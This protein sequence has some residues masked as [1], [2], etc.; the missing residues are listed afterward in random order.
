MMK[1]LFFII[2]LSFFSFELFAESNVDK[3][4]MRADSLIKSFEES[5]SIVDANKAVR[6]FV[7]DSYKFN[8]DEIID[9]VKLQVYDCYSQYLFNHG[10]FTECYKNANATLK[11]AISSD[12]F[13]IQSS[14]YS[15][16]SLCYEHWGDYEK[17]IT[18]AKKSFD[19]E[20]ING[21]PLE[22]AVTLNNISELYYTIGRY[23]EALE[24]NKKF[25]DMVSKIDDQEKK[26]R[27]TSIAYGSASMIYNGL[28]Q[29]ELAYELAEKGYIIDSLANRHEAASIR[30]YQMAENLKDMGHTRD[31][32]AFFE[33]L[34]D[35]TNPYSFRR[36]RKIDFLVNT[37][38]NLKQHEEALKYARE[39]GDIHAQQINLRY[40]ALEEEDHE[41]AVADMEESFQLLD[42]M[43]VIK[44][45]ALKEGLYAD[46]QHSVDEY[47]NQMHS[48]KVTM[49]ASVLILL[50]AFLAI[51][52]FGWIRNRKICKKL[53]K[54]D[55]VKDNLIKII[56]RELSNSVFDINTYSHLLSDNVNEED[57]K[58]LISCSDSQKQVLENILVWSRMHCLDNEELRKTDIQMRSFVQDAIV[59]NR[60]LAENKNVIL[61]CQYSEDCTISS[62]TAFLNIL[63]DSLISN[64]V[65]ASEEGA[66]VIIRFD[67]NS[68]SVIDSGKLIDEKAKSILDSKV[69]L[70]NNDKV[71]LSYQII[72]DVLKILGLSFDIVSKEEEGNNFTVKF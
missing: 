61:V 39:T 7:G 23:K 71:F 2:L 54:T 62:D 29:Y 70:N 58:S 57:L 11:K 8:N 64:A 4:L 19:I 9:D 3:Q 41:K 13:E 36:L 60:T 35:S 42:S 38:T 68:L 22:V 14:C 47:E 51:S 17:A 72:K 15:I 66:S 1:R 24:Y 6:F 25:L 50:I 34:A 63:I 65:E 67:N 33:S 5:R 20:S 18:Y 46:L 28:E 55:E 44:T 26:S 37:L 49:I 10:Y 56:S 52:V 30:R 69:K 12:F 53:T 31:A 27:Y 21:T 48:Q 45:R 32:I 40:I 43:N 59:R 16:I